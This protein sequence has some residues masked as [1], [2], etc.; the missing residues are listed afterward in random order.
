MLSVFDISWRHFERGFSN[1]VKQLNDAKPESK[2]FHIT[3]VS[4]HV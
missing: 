1:L 3:S 2:D 4:R